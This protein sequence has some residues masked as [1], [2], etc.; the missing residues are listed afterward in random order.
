MKTTWT[1]LSS[2]DK[3]K[4]KQ[5]FMEHESI[6]FIAETFNVPRTSIQYHA[7]QKSNCWEVEREMMK[8]ELFQ[9]FSSTKRG[10][11]IKMSDKAIKI[12]TRSLGNLAEREHPPTTREAKDA[13]VILESL[14]KITR[15][16]DGTPTEITGEKVMEMK[17]I[18][19]IATLIPFKSKKKNKTVEEIVYQEED[20]DDKKT[21]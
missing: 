2:E 16:D 8:A 9:K 11:F 13:V 6:A 10:A 17:D 20:K 15:L 4:A 7:T 5:L 19:A 18:E 21:K 14:D 12:I 3:E 1:K